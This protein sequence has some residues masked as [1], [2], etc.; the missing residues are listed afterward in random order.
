M[1]NFVN[2]QESVSK[3]LILTHFIS[4][5]TPCATMAGQMTVADMERA[6]TAIEKKLRTETTR[7][8]VSDMLQLSG[9]V[10]PG[11]TRSQQ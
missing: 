4:G 2:L 5:K 10:A 8:K 9:S 11:A 3:M 1:R 6:L 7:V